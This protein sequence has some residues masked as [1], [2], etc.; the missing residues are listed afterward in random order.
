MAPNVLFT[1]YQPPQK[2]IGCGLVSVVLLNQKLNGEIGHSM[3]TN[4]KYNT[5]AL[6]TQ[7]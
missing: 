1:K 2:R 7:Y 3:N 4:L 6:Q 5:K